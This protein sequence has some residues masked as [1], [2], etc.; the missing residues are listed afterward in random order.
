MGILNTIRNRTNNVRVSF[1]TNAWEPVFAP[2]DIDHAPI[3]KALQE[4]KIKGF[5]CDAGF[6]IE[7]ITKQNRSSYF[8]KPHM[9]VRIDTPIHIQNGRFEI[10]MS[11]GPDNGRHPSLPDVQAR[12]LQRALATGFKLMSG[13]NW[14]GLPVPGEIRDPRNYVH[15]DA[16]ATR[17]REERQFDIMGGIEARGVGKVKF[18]AADGWTERPRRPPRRSG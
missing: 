16:D 3:R 1:D 2:N 6:R 10:A 9:E 15:E 4:G 13:E 14:I 8:A 17:R 18:D 7:A 5:I 12:K 11:I